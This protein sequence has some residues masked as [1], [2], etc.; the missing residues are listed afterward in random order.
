MLRKFEV[1]MKKSQ[2]S[3]MKLADVITIKNQLREKLFKEIQGIRTSSYKYADIKKVDPKDLK[4][5]VKQIK[6]KLGY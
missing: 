4:S 5:I 1:S 6:N 3:K 2:L